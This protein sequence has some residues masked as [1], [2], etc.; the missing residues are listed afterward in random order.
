[1]VILSFMKDVGEKLVIA[2]EPHPVCASSLYM[3]LAKLQLPVLGLEITVDGDQV[4]IAGQVGSTEDAEKIV[5][6]LGNTVGVA[7]VDNR[8]H[9]LSPSPAAELYT[10][11]RGDTLWKIAEIHYGRGQGSKYPAIYEAN[12]PM[13][14]HPDSIYPGQVLRIPPLG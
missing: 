12:K 13:L 4:I 1:M 8:L 3:A 11:R 2:D 14:A 5:L 10:V 9:V 7:S 6:A